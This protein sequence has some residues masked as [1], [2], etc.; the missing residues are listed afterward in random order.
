MSSYSLGTQFVSEMLAMVVVVWIGESVL[1]NELLVKTKGHEMGIAA[2]SIGFGLAFFI[3]LAMF[4][5]VS[6][7]VNPC[8]LFAKW[9]AGKVTT[10]QW[11]VLSIADFVGAFIGAVMVWLTYLAHFCLVP[12]VPEAKHL[13]RN[14]YAALTTREAYISNPGVR[15]R[16]MKDADEINIFSTNN[17]TQRKHRAS[18]QVAALARTRIHNNL[19]SATNT[20]RTV[21]SDGSSEADKRRDIEPTPVLEKRT[22]D[23]TNRE[24]ISLG[25]VEG[26]D[27]QTATNSKDDELTDMPPELIAYEILLVQ[28]QNAKLSVFATRPAILNIPTNLLT[29]I[30]ITFG[31]IWFSL[32]ITEQSYFMPDE[33]GATSFERQSVAPFIG[34]LVICCVVAFTGPTGFAANAA[35]DFGPR[36]AHYALPI[37]NKGPSEWRYAWVP[38]VGPYIGGMLAGF[39]FVGCRQLLQYPEWAQ[40][41]VFSQ[42]MFG[43]L[44]NVF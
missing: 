11:I 37:P 27:K 20:E 14:K 15:K 5:E 42:T 25:G 8:T 19:N 32:M 44:T 4:D 26:C 17:S 6:A 18:I 23:H 28:D 43:T 12:D 10:K 38:I 40:S 30:L 2:V 7:T 29:E 9:I 36:C 33:D 3:S 16:S 21:L 41:T 22:E 1:A 34:A 39:M 24:P 31:L 13:E 35:R